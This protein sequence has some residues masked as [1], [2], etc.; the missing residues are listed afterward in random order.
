MQIR[1]MNKTGILLK[2]FEDEIHPLN[3][4]AVKCIRLNAHLEVTVG[5]II[6]TMHLIRL[7]YEKKSFEHLQCL[8]VVYICRMNVFQWYEPL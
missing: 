3:Y 8:L 1:F 7:F 5:Q 2:T 4:S 6:H